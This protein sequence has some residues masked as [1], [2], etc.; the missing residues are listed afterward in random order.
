M[1]NGAADTYKSPRAL[2]FPPFVKGGLK[3]DLYMPN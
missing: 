3:G 2:R 1:T